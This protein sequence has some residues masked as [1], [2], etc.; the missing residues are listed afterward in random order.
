MVEKLL[1]MEIGGWVEARQARKGR[2]GNPSPD[3]GRIEDVE[4][5][6]DPVACGLEYVHRVCRGV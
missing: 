4:E 3:R 6:M 5:H 2:C 1:M